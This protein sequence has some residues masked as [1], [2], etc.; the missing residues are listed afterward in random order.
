MHA[1]EWMLCLTG[2]LTA[3]GMLIHAMEDHHQQ[4]SET[5]TFWNE[6][7]EKLRCSK[8]LDE[9]DTHYVLI[10]NTPCAL[11]DFALHANSGFSLVMGMDGNHYE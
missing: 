2:L 1:L 8:E 10:F 9:T 5:N 6:N 4:L 7:Q 3:M 11:F